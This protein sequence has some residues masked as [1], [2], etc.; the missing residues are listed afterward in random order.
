MF[1]RGSSVQEKLSQRFNS[2]DLLL[3]LL[4]LVE[5]VCVGVF[6]AVIVVG[7]VGVLRDFGERGRISSPVSGSGATGPPGF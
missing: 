3:L 1:V 7:G 6:G 2:S 5:T 4:L